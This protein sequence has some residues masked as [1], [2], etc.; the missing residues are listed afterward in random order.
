MTL[1]AYFSLFSPSRALCPLARLALLG[2]LSVSVAACAD[3]ETR[4]IFGNTGGAGGSGGQGGT[5]GQGGVSGSYCITAEDCPEGNFCNFAACINN[6]C[7]YKALPEGTRTESQVPEDCR[8]SRCDGMGQII[9]VEVSNDAPSDGLECTADYCEGG[10]AKHDAVAQGT[11]CSTGTCNAE[12]ICA[13]C[14]DDVDCAQGSCG[15]VS[16]IAGFCRGQ[17]LDQ[18]DYCIALYEV[19]NAEYAVFLQGNDPGQD[20]ECAFNT[21]YV[22]ANGAP[23]LNDQPVTGVDWCDATAYCKSVGKTLCGARSGGGIDPSSFVDAAQDAWFDT[24]SSGGSLAFPYGDAYSATTCNGEQAG[25][26]APAAVGSFIACREPS[27]PLESPYDLS[28]NVWEWENA[29]ASTTGTGDACRVRGG[30]FNNDAS[31]LSCDT[32]Y[33][34]KRGAAY[35]SVGIRCCSN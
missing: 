19:T 28:G 8:E 29:C 31:S 17:M 30:S 10:L 16:C 15:G 25:V 32:D 26:G 11:P 9:V 18:G 21:S 7:S 33:A 4:I 12:G 2:L 20:A 34:I 27:G 35:D 22:P 5:G 1:G 14:L 6:A 13:E 23:V 3:E 24:C